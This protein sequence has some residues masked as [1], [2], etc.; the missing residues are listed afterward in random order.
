MLY[1]L[2]RIQKKAFDERDSANHLLHQNSLKTNEPKGD[3]RII[4]IS[5]NCSS[6][7]TLISLAAIMIICLLFSPC[8][9]QKGLLSCSLWKN[10]FQGCGTFFF[11]S[12]SLLKIFPEPCFSSFSDLP[13][14][15][16][17]LL[18]TNPHLSGNVFPNI[19]I[20][21]LCWRIHITSFTNST[22][23][24]VFLATLIQHWFAFVSWCT[25]K[26]QYWVCFSTFMRV[27]ALSCI[28]IFFLSFFSPICKDHQ[29]S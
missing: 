25:V 19:S 13:N 22:T 8:T 16:S 10:L 17:V 26:N 1:E 29:K 11:Q 21:V 15:V 20:H 27:L 18:L 4:K 28:C 2:F 24:F 9:G 14:F 23:A 5:E 6:Y 7:L 12:R 3:Y